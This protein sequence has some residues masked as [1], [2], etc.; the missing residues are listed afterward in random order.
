MTRGEDGMTFIRAH[1]HMHL[2][3]YARQVFDV[4]GAGDTVIGVL[5]AAIAAGESFEQATMLA[6][7]AASLVVGKL[8]AATVSAPE[9]QVALTGKSTYSSGIVNEEQ[10]L[11]AITEARTQGKKIIF[12]NGCFDILHA[13][14]VTYLQVAKQLGDYLIVAV[15][16]DASIT[17]LKGPNRPINNM[18]HRMTVLQAWCGGLGGAFCR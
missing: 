14:H 7:L 6:N 8:G 4:T 11:R 10:L 17:R 16:D 9:L 1:D 5:G 15:N 13:G 3:A 2:P 18:H 12:T